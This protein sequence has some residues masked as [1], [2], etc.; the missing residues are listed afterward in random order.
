MKKQEDIN[1]NMSLFLILVGFK[2][3]GFF[4]NILISL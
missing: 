1:Y 2:F 4:L 3:C